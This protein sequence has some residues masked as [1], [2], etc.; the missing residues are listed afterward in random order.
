MKKFI[1]IAVAF[2]LMLILIGCAT[3]SSEE[4]K[5]TYDLKNSVGNQT[6]V[7][8]SSSDTRSLCWSGMM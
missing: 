2:M 3:M 8:E 4:R 1:S 6:F 7:G 5:E